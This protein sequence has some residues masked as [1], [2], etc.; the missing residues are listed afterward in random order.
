VAL[1]SYVVSNEAM[2]VVVVCCGEKKARYS[3]N[4]ISNLEKESFRK[5][6]NCLHENCL[7]GIS[8]EF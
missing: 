1:Y 4:G 2:L 3:S 6:K 8:P 5:A 7:H